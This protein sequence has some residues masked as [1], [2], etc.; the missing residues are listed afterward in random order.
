MVV[1]YNRGVRSGSS[2]NFGYD[3]RDVKNKGG[4]SALPKLPR[5]NNSML[6]KGAYLP[7]ISNLPDMSALR[8]NMQETLNERAKRL[9]EEKKAESPSRSSKELSEE[10]IKAIRARQGGN[11]ILSMFGLSG[12]SEPVIQQREKTPEEKAR[13][14]LTGISEGTTEL[15]LLDA[16]DVLAQSPVI[17]EE[18]MYDPAPTLTATN[19]EPAPEPVANRGASIYSE[20]A[21]LGGGL[22]GVNVTELA[23]SYADST[24][25][26]LNASDIFAATEP[27]PNTPNQGASIYSEYANLGGG[28]GGVNVTELANSYAD[29]TNPLLNA[30]DASDVNN[31]LDTIAGKSEDKTTLDVINNT[32]DTIAGKSEDETT[33][34]VINNTLDSIASNAVIGTG[35]GTGTGTTDTGDNPLLG[36][37]DIFQ[38][39]INN[40]TLPTTTPG[41]QVI[42]PTKVDT[43]SPYTGY[44]QYY[45]S[46]QAGQ[47]T[48]VPGAG[49]TL[50]GMT[51]NPYTGFLQSSSTYFGAPF[52]Q[53][54]YTP[55]QSPMGYE[56][57]A[58]L[59]QFTSPD[60]TYT[61]TV[62][63][64]NAVPRYQQQMIAQNDYQ[65]PTGSISFGQGPRLNKPLEGYNYTSYGNMN[66]VFNPAATSP[67]SSYVSPTT[68]ESAQT[69]TTG[70]TGFS[71]FANFR[72]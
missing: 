66:P 25:P 67:T 59:N 21:N 64:P 26:L 39:E 40:Q 10:Y 12:K 22:G 72:G 1:R 37:S 60:Q 38:E 42:A 48:G 34:D 43:I 55:Y 14:I 27:T 61:N 49:S 54:S 71:G 45:S 41:T 8:N 24:N 52:T 69:A 2:N 58:A 29:S 65:N 6:L 18:P 36:A 56:G 30:S 28:L 15:D 16:L 9:Q 44:S 32:L 68:Q 33:L 20:Y 5:L 23:N 19:R 17:Y 63:D 62:T 51:V 46:G 31:T 47:T 11:K 13:D 3:S 57:N 50:E 53:Q 7:N 4:L 70:G 35:T